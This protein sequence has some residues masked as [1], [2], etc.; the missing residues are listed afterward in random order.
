MGLGSYNS[1]HSIHILFVSLLNPHSLVPRFIS[2]DTL[3]LLCLPPSPAPLSIS[4]LPHSTGWMVGWLGCQWIDLV[5]GV[6]GACWLVKSRS[7][8][9]GSSGKLRF[10][11][12]M[13]W[14]LFCTT[15]W[16]I[17]KLRQMVS[18]LNYLFMD[19]I[20]W[21]PSKR[22]TSEPMWRWDLKFNSIGVEINLKY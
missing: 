11:I 14:L 4:L 1:G 21:H 19:F 13:L 18:L 6:A 15:R 2:F 7:P 9:E 16:S 10:I 8:P 12:T 17:Q 5:S 20:Y 3:R 22:I